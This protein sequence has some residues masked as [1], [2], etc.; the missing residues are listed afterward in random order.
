MTRIVLAL[1]ILWIGSATFSAQQRPASSGQPA[2]KVF[3]LNGC[4]TSEPGAAG[5]FKLMGATPVGQAPPEHAAT[6]DAP[7]GEYVLLPVTGL[8]EQGVAKP[9]LQTHLGR[10]VEV[11]VRPVEVAPAPSPSSPSSASPAAP[12]VKDQNDVPP[13]Y[14]VVAVKSAAGSCPRR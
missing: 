2:H 14:T 11:T 6:A 1:A 8:T 9:E 12:V 4:L 3:I 10:R 7:K 13:R 5:A